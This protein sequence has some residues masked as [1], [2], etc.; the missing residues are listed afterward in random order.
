MSK[1]NMKWGILTDYKDSTS[2]Q[3]RRCR[4][5]MINIG[6]ESR[7][8]MMCEGCSSAESKQTCRQTLNWRLSY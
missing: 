1:R 7:M 5:E 8:Y 3:A 4:V 2:Q 6:D